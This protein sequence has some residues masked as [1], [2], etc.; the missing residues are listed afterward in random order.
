VLRPDRGYADI[1]PQIY[2]CSVQVIHFNT[3]HHDVS[4]LLEFSEHSSSCGFI[5][6]HHNV[7]LFIILA[8]PGSPS[9][10]ECAGH[11]DFNGAVYE[12]DC[13][14]WCL[15]IN[16]IRVCLSS[17]EEWRYCC[18]I[19]Q[20]PYSIILCL[21]VYRLSSIVHSHIRVRCVGHHQ[22]SRCSLQFL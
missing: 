13:R 7:G 12:N 9:H 18:W 17:L 8:V 21:I 16:C 3:N 2:I 11:Q 1:I 6:S 5:S 4:L 10:V 20:V 19:N 14:V 15:G 22:R